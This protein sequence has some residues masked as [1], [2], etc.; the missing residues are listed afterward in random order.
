MYPGI[1]EKLDYIAT[2]GIRTIWLTSIYKSPLKD[3]RHGVE[4]FRDIDPIFGTMRD[5]E[6]LVAAIHDRGGWVEGNHGWW[7]LAD[8]PAPALP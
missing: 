8:T 4:D 2:L 6:E 7:R 3:F 1:V 5:F